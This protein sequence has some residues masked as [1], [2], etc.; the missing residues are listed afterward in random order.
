MEF[1]TY[2]NYAIGIQ[3]VRQV[4]GLFIIISVLI[5][6]LFLVASGFITVYRVKRKLDKKKG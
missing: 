6:A 3:E 4:V 2:L 1:I 5:A